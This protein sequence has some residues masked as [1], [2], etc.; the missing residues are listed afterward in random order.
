[1]ASPPNIIVLTD[2]VRNA[3]LAKINANFADLYGT[4]GTSPEGGYAD[5]ATRL[6]ALAALIIAAGSGTALVVAQDAEPTAPFD[7]LVWIDT[8]SS[9]KNQVQ[10]YN[11]TA[12]AWQSVQDFTRANT[13]SAV[14]TFQAASLL[15]VVADPT[16][17]AGQL[18][19]YVK[20]V[21]GV[22][23]LHAREENNGTVHQITGTQ[24]YL[25]EIPIPAAAFG[26]STT[27]G[28][29]AGSH[30]YG[31]NDVDR[32]HI[33]LSG[34]TKEYS[35]CSW[36]MPTDW[37]GGSF[38]VKLPWSSDTGS[39]NGEGVTLGVQAKCCGDGDDIDSAWGAA[40]EVSDTLQAD[41]GTKQQFTPATAAVTPAGTPAGGEMLDLR[42]YRDPDNVND[43]MAEDAWV[44]GAVLQITRTGEPAAF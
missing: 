43:D 2:I 34:T 32:Y 40:Q 9:P 13:W 23:Q 29:E 11:A 38:K 24:S 44:H 12:V 10:V 18:A 15:E 14:Q 4:I 31:T 30:E 19:L 41:N 3:L 33:A 1:M 16:T 27:S 35:A 7:G 5:V 26:P 25:D 22:P 42:I 36:P 21:S 20:D 28:G 8:N 39:S 17:G 37:D 6:D